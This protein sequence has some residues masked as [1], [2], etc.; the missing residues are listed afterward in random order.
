[1]A[2]F[3]A[4]E[5]VLDAEGKHVSDRIT[6][7]CSSITLLEK[8]L[9]RHRDTF[10]LEEGQR[11]ADRVYVYKVK[12]Y[13]GAAHGIYI[14][15]G[16]RLKRRRNSSFTFGFCDPNGDKDHTYPSVVYPHKE[17]NRWER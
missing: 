3:Y 17:A 13:S 7:V 1:M 16:G 6:P 14:V 15:E 11:F 8:K 9:L 10:P 5:Q 4:K 12:K 2:G